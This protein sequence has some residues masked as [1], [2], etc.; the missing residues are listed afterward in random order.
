[1]EWK[2]IGICILCLCTLWVSSSVAVLFQSYSDLPWQHLHGTTIDSTKNEW[3]EFLCERVYE[4]VEV[5]VSIKIRE[6]QP[7]SVPVQFDSDPQRF[8]LH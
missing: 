4:S 6:R 8:L 7:S 1:M 3:K 5:C 2:T